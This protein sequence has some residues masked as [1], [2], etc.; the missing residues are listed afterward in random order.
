M[1]NLGLMIMEQVAAVEKKLKEEHANAMKQEHTRMNELKVE[2]GRRTASLEE[3][4]ATYKETVQ[5][6]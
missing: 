4:T 2:L 5:V 6:R 3:L 1:P